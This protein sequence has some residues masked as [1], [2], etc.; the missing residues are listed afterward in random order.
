MVVAIAL[1]A[2]YKARHSPKVAIEAV[3]RRTVRVKPNMHVTPTGV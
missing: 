2:K 1:K 3:D